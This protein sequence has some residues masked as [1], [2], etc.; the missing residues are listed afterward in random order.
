MALLEIDELGLDPGDRLLLSAIID[1]YNGGPVGVD[2]LAALIADER[3]TIEDFYEPYL[4]QIGLIE[5]T[6]RGR[7]VTPK[8]YKHL[9]KKHNM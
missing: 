3:S 5:R 8:A 7:K 2:T 6:P 4:L 1:N 9:G